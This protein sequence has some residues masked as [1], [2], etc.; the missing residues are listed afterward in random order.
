MTCASCDQFDVEI[1]IQSPAHFVRIS[2]KIRNAI[3]DGILVYN[4]FESDR[5]LFG[6]PSFL[7]LEQKGPFP[8]V[9]RYHFSCPICRDCYGLFVETYHGSGGT[10]SVLKRQ[11]S[12]RTV[13]LAGSNKIKFFSDLWTAI[14]S[15]FR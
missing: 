7:T 5:E 1:N 8:D 4:S 13:S 14:R 11:N 3:A 15:R 10:W 12:N 2:G 9:M 6:Q